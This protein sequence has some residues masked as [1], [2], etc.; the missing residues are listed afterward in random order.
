MEQKLT[1]S[2]FGHEK[3]VGNDKMIFYTRLISALWKFLELK[4]CTPKRS[5]ISQRML[6]LLFF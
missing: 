4:T 1:E 5:K 6:F 3:F 2:K